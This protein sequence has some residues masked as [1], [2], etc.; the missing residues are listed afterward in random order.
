MELQPYL[1]TIARNFDATSVFV[2]FLVIIV[3]AHLVPYLSD[4]AGLRAYPG[5]TLAKLSRAWPAWI[6]YH[7]RI[8]TSVH[9]AHE[10]YGTFVR[11]SPVE[12]SIAHPEALQQIYGHN[13]GTTKSDMYDAFTQFGGIPS[14]FAARDR[15]EHARKRKIMSHSMSL[16]S[17]SEFEP[18][19][20][21][22]QRIL[23]QK[24]DRIC[25][26]GAKGSGGVEGSCVWQAENG[27]AWFDCDLAFGSPFG[28]LVAARDSTQIA[29]SQKAAMESYGVEDAKL[30]YVTI[31]A[32][33]AVNVASSIVV[34]LGVLPPWI[35]PIMARFFA[36]KM[37]ATGELASMVVTAVAKRLVSSVSRQDL[38]SKLLEG[39]DEQDTALSKNEL[40]AESLTLLVAG[41]DTTANSTGAITYFLAQNPNIQAKLQEVL[42]QVLGPPGGDSENGDVA[43]YNEIKNIE[44]L[45]DVINEG[46]RLHSTVGV[47]LPRVVP[48]SGMTVLGK[49]FAPGTVVSCP[50]Y[51]LHRLP[52][53]WGNDAEVFNPERWSKGDRAT[54][55]KAFAPFSVGPR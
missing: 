30:E 42:D 11:I 51:T 54:M 31:S 44:Y 28:M 50:L 39:R 4:P 25:E 27:R 36:T 37:R 40:S 20:H 14:V 29:T 34:F 5:P 26:A 47:G 23:I 12:V 22:Y 48:E 10:K 16:K 19:I 15:V 33:D 9:E 8:S 21:T 52:S 1:H 55:L 32:V 46:L 35:R 53:V 24:W 38:L 2:V 18:I 6:A 3:L 41:S 7:D 43:S 13:T 49:T 45:Q 17:V